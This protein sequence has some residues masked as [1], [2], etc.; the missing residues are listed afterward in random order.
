MS[1]RSSS[2]TND[3]PSK[4]RRTRVHTAARPT[5]A[6]QPS[7]IH[8]VQ[9]TESNESRFTQK[10]HDNTNH[11]PLLPNDAVVEPD[12]AIDEW[13][14]E[15]TPVDNMPSANTPK[16]RKSKS[17]LVSFHSFHRIFVQWELS[18]SFWSP[19][20]NTLPVISLILIKATHRA[21]Y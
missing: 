21:T 8:H 11:V 5:S 18:S 9:L 15:D 17:T 19:G 1:N 4:K 2:S 7:G 12:K 20:A 6:P 14:N 13:V 10:W 3:N 16:K